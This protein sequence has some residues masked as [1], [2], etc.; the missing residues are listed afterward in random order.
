MIDFFVPLFGTI[1][2]TLASLFGLFWLQ[3]RWI[4]KN[5]DL[6][7]DVR[8]FP[9]PQNGPVS[10]VPAPVEEKP[11][12][13]PDPR[14]AE[15]S[16]AD[17]KGA[18]KLTRIMCDEMGLTKRQKDILCACI[19][20]ESRFMNRYPNGK[21]VINQNKKNGQV[22]STDYGIIQVNDYWHIGPGKTFPSVAY[23]MDNPDKMVRWMVREMKRTGRLQPW[24]SY[25]SGAYKQWL[26]PSSPMWALN[27]W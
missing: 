20:Q 14:I 6:V 12:P 4:R 23:V 26:S 18:Y 5:T 1:G 13:G 24:S 10:P 9:E 7:V 27:P 22:W 2:A 17:P 15:L 11:A 21:P 3:D 25:V 19:F 8:A 16:W